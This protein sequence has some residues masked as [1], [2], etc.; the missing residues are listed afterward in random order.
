MLTMKL[1]ILPN[2][3]MHEAESNERLLGRAEIKSVQLERTPKMPALPLPEKTRRLGRISPGSLT[4]EM[5]RQRPPQ[6]SPPPSPRLAGPIPMRGTI[7]CQVAP[8]V[9]PVHIPARCMPCRQWTL[10]PAS[11]TIR[12]Q[13]PPVCCSVHTLQ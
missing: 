3:H 12:H 2:H 8:V 10:R 1:V 11:A 4:Y 13:T 5:W 7:D 9:V 6:H